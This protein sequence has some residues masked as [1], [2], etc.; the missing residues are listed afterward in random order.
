MLIFFSI[1]ALKFKISSKTMRH[2]HTENE[3]RWRNFFIKVALTLLSTAVVVWFLPR[4]EQEV[5]KYDLGKPWTYGT[6]IAPFDFPVLKSDETIKHESDSL[7]RQFEPYYVYDNS[8]EAEQIDRLHKDY[9]HGFAGVSFSYLGYIEKKMHE[10][11]QVGIIDD[12]AYDSLSRDTTRS[13]RLV[14]GN[15]ATSIDIRE[16]YSVTSAYDKIFADPMLSLVKGLLASVHL[17]KYL[18][19]NIIRDEERT[20]SECEELVAS[21]ARSSGIVQG[22]QKII[23][24]GEIVDHRTYNVLKSYEKEVVKHAS[25]REKVTTL[26]GQILFV[27][28]LMLLTTSYLTL[29]RGDYFYK[30]RSLV[31]LYM[32]LTIFPVMVSLMVSHHFLS[33][34]VLPMAMAP[35]FI[36]VFMDSRTAFMVHAV[37]TMLCAAAVKYQY[38]F[39]LIQ[40]TSGLVAIYTLRELSKRSQVFIAAAMVTI[41]ELIIYFTLELMQNT[42]QFNIP[43]VTIYYFLAGGVLLLLTY[44]MM[45]V[46]EKLFGF[47]ST[48]TLFELSDTNRD[49]LRRLSEVAPGTFQHSIT[50]SNLAS[51]IAKRIGA[52]ALMVRVGAL[53]HDIGKMSNPIFF[54][55]N[56]NGIN[57]HSRLTETESAQMIISHVTEGMRM[58]EKAGLPDMITDF[59]RT[60][61]GTGLT[62]YFYIQYKNKHPEEAVDERLFSYP[63]PNPFT[64]EQAILMMADTVEAAARS[65]PEYT[66]ESVTA[67]VNRLIDGQ[68]QQGYYRDCPI[69]FQDIAIAK[70]VL[71]ENLMSIYHTRIAYPEEKKQD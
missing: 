60:H 49:L 16:R 26:I 36:R 45:F 30:P 61:H 63:G 52:K 28:V 8:K 13:I 65:L 37:I 25:Q 57:P 24:R 68:V 56:Q 18:Q 62:K 41:T 43:P 34:Y 3:H 48:V 21:I 20:Q 46:V 32:L 71:I 47:V 44:P 70:V 66:Q 38:E 2:I 17:E 58:A 39:I 33:V 64:S 69:T 51:E 54:T 23:D 55:E 1:F 15:S 35:M 59:I 42:D 27:F 53:Y 12:V 10:V 4:N 6:F 29:Y 40:L 11:Y 7:I 67:L 50:V 31:M 19:P 14:S 5:Y 9:S 22:G